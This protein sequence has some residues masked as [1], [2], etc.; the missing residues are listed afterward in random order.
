MPRAKSTNSNELPLK[1]KLLKEQLAVP[2][3][4]ASF[5]KSTWTWRA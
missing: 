5:I 2:L 1:S 3:A 4:G